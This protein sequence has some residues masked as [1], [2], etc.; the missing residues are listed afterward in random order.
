MGET[1]GFEMVT[2]S[3]TPDI[4]A[5]AASIG[6]PCALPSRMRKNEPYVGGDQ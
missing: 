3:K 1:T 5:A 4:K 2:I 6:Y